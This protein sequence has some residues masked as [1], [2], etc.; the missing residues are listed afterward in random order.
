MFPDDLV[1]NRGLLHERLGDGPNLIWRFA[2]EGDDVGVTAPWYPPAHSSLLALVGDA[3]VE[4]V[5]LRGQAEDDG[6]GFSVGADVFTATS[7]VTLTASKVGGRDVTWRVFAVGRSTISK[8]E[9]AATADAFLAGNSEWPKVRHAVV[10]FAD[11]RELALTPN[12]QSSR[13]REELA[14]LVLSFVRALK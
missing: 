6:V 13:D 9:V 8:V 10:T 11:G 14:D 4:F 3:R 7:V 5:N 1:P 12:G 2:V